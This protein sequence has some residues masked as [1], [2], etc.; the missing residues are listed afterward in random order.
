MILNTKGFLALYNTHLTGFVIRFI[1][2]YEQYI[3]KKTYKIY[4]KVSGLRKIFA[5]NLVHLDLDD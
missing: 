3:S 2:R 1:L 5:G 4:F